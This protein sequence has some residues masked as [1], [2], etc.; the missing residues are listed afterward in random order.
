MGICEWTEHEACVSV[1]RRLDL[2]VCERLDHQIWFS[3]EMICVTLA[4][5]FLCSL[6]AKLK[7]M[8]YHTSRINCVAW[9]QDSTRVATG[10]VDTS[11]IVYDVG[12][13]ATARTTIKAAHLGGV[14][15]LGFI[16]PLT[17]ASG[18]DDA[19]LRLWKLAQN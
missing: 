19:C 3:M 17:V 10:S 7:N 13:P 8:L 16:D 9:S 1:S 15:C 14:T 18:G 4:F 6:Q 2:A 12:K 11:I 5:L